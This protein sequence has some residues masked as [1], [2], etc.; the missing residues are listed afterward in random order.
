MN[1]YILLLFFGILKVS[2][3]YT[4]TVQATL[5]LIPPHSPLLANY[6][7]PSSNGL[8]LTLITHDAPTNTIDVWLKLDITGPISMHT[9]ST[10]APSGPI[11]LT[12][13][14]PLILYG[15]EL[16]EY[17]DPYNLDFTNT[18]RQDFINGGGVLNEGFYNFCFQ[19]FAPN[20]N[21]QTPLSNKSCDFA[22]VEWFDPPMIIN[23]IGNQTPVTPQ[24]LL[25]NWQ[26]RH[27]G[28]FLTD[29]T[30]EVWEVISGMSYQQMVNNEPPTFQSNLNTTTFLY[31]AAEPVLTTGKEYI[32]RVRAQAPNGVIIFKNSGYS[33]IKPF[34]YGGDCPEPVN[35]KMD[36]SG[37]YLTLTWDA[38]PGDFVN[39]YTIRYK[40]VGN[41]PAN[42]VT[43]PIVE[44]ATQ[45]VL[46][47]LF[48]NN[49][50]EIEIRSNCS[51]TQSNWVN[52]GI[53]EIKEEEIYECG[54][55][56]GAYPQGGSTPLPTLKKDEEFNAGDF[57]VKVTSVS[58]GNGHFFG[59]G[60]VEVPYFNKARVNVKYNGITINEERFM[61]QG[62]VIVTG[63]GLQLV[64]DELAGMLDDILN[65][66]N[67]IDDLLAASQSILETLDELIALVEPYLPGTV[68]QDL[69]DAQQTLQEALAM[70]NDPNVTPAQAQAA[71]EAAQE[72][73]NEA[74]AAFQAALLEFLGQFKDII[75][76]AISELYTEYQGQKATLESNYNTK[77]SDLDTWLTSTNPTYNIPPS[78]GSGNT[79]S[80]LL[81]SEVSE[82]TPPSNDPNYNTFVQKSEAY[83]NAEVPYTVVLVID[84]LKTQLISSDLQPTKQFA[85]LLKEEG[86]DLLS[87]VGQR[88]KDNVAE[89]LIVDYAK[90][91]ILN[92]LT[93]ILI[94]I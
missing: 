72:Q 39:S 58:G 44:N 94:K 48:I 4:Q 2:S 64:S 62:E 43:E 1:K 25:F 66:V 71:L 35:V 61:T 53:K 47:E 38:P 33:E 49:S 93:K 51:I 91:E 24:S 17:F 55:A 65:A 69:I 10:F 18:N 73:L 34:I 22:Y 15:F 85:A 86:Y 59:Q 42:W 56:P 40:G 67:T 79:S 8:M 80:L 23:P 60:Y 41:D 81:S 89:P 78:S 31:G 70:A 46:Q 68:V 45:Y 76:T 77:K 90:S 29:Y 82:F 26:P 52:L 12:N 30:L 74:N 27:I 11:T 57:K 20:S 3:S 88:I 84:K 9:S 54:L 92:G 63:V 19:A 36:V 16:Q 6:T 14:V 75:I 32:T 7:S 37:M 5:S 50:Y 87:G 21:Y 83:F 13:N 28:S